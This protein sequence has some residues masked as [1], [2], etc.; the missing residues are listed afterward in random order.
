MYLS[1]SKCST[2]TLVKIGFNLMVQFEEL[3]SM[4]Y[5]TF[6]LLRLKFNE[7]SNG[8]HLTCLIKI[9]VFYLKFRFYIQVSMYIWWFSKVSIIRNEIS[10]TFSIMNSIIKFTS[11]MLIVVF[12]MRRNCYSLREFLITRI[13]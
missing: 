4:W 5:V 3:H 2:S 9:F 1:C 10:C 6:T 8:L 13:L 11:L 7:K 12:H